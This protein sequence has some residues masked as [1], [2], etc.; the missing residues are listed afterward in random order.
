MNQFN[1]VLS[2]PGACQLLLQALEESWKNY[3]KELKRCKKEF[4]N[5]AV[6]DLRVATRRVMTVVQLLQAIAPRPRLQKVMRTF[7]D[8][9]DELD[10]LRDTQVILAEIS[11][12]IHE[13]PEFHGFQKHQQI[14]EEKS[15]RSLRKK[16][17]KFNPVLLAK[18]IHK[19][20]HFLERE[21]DASLDH[22]LLQPVDDAYL[23]AKQRLDWVDSGRPVTIQRVGS[24]FR[25]FRCMVE[26]V[27]PLLEGFPPNNL[28]GMYRY[29]S[30]M[31]E[32]QDAQVFMQTLAD[33]FEHTSISGLESIRHYYESRHDE[34]V[35]AYIKD[36]NQFH[37]FWRPAPDQP[38]PWEQRGE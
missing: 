28:E 33:F 23:I 1:V 16:I 24:A 7:Q 2:K 21:M 25:V 37:H 32:I 30:L 9:L 22:Q 10:D 26:L 18:R 6:H 3:L 29:Q 20:H 35:N 4:S 19:A 14:L 13:L 38:F 17:K 27:H 36:M 34:S 12:T 5:E 8:Q 11:E 15:L 31:E